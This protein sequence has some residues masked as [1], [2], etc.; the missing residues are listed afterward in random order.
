[1]ADYTNTFADFADGD[2][3]SAAALATQFDA[4]AASLLTKGNK[5]QI[6]DQTGNFVDLDLYWYGDLPT[7]LSAGFGEEF[8]E[9]DDLDLTVATDID[10]DASLGNSFGITVTGGTGA[11]LPVLNPPTN[12]RPGQEIVLLVARGAGALA[13]DAFM[14]AG[15]GLKTAS[16][17]SKNLSFDA[18]IGA[19]G[20][21]NFYRMLFDGT[22]WYAWLEQN[23]IS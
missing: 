15:T 7:T 10:I 5:S 2:T 21:I 8:V 16:N 20:R 1:M 3:V 22:T 6:Q 12:G 19:V 9:L 11:G 23:Q 4:I 13:A 18:I 14:Q 17:F